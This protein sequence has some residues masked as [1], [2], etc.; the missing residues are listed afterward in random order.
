[1]DEQMGRSNSKDSNEWPPLLEYV[2]KEYRERNSEWEKEELRAPT[3]I[4]K[5]TRGIKW[6]VG[7]RGFGFWK[8]AGDRFEDLYT[9][10][11][12]G[13]VWA[14]IR[15]HNI[16]G[17]ILYWLTKSWLPNVHYSHMTSRD[18]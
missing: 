16:R 6:S 2:A 15:K 5:R 18:D 8:H 13:F 9:I 14:Y 1:M 4:V 17:K 10:F 3:I 7:G 12:V 11:K